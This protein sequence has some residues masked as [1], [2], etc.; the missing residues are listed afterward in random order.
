MASQYAVCTASTGSSIFTGDED[1]G[2]QLFQSLDTEGVGKISL[3]QYLGWFAS[4]HG[5]S[6]D[7]GDL[8]GESVIGAV[9]YFHRY[10][11]LMDD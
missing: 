7:I 4:K 6:G 9:E 3:V 10:V 1:C 5:G 11:C 8:E 2:S